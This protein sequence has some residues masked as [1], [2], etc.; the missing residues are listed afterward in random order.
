M[1]ES[2]ETLVPRWS[3]AERRLYPG[4]LTDPVGYERR[5]LAVRSLA[6]E[7]SAVP[8]LEALAD[9]FTGALPR[10]AAA[11]EAVGGPADGSSAE[12]VAG[13][14]F[15]LAHRALHASA[16]GAER[17]RRIAEAA[18]SG[19]PW[20]TVAERGNRSL[21]G[22]GEYRRLEMH[23]PDGTGVYAYVE[24]AAGAEQGGEPGDRF[25]LERVPLDPRTGAALG[26]A[27]QR[28]TFGDLGSWEAAATELRAAGGG[29]PATLD[30]QFPAG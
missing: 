22:F 19:A 26:E 21:A 27:L 6:D 4:V 3:L 15:A 1:A 28:W 11:L 10:A 14:A 7:L 16:A 24:A 13:A 18:A 8:T 23:L 20:V 12:L 30:R 29:P 5:L 17:A 9:E 2:L 25:V